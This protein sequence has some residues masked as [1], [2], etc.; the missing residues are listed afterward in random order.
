MDPPS[1]AFTTQQ[2]SA[3]ASLQEIGGHKPT[4][5]PDGAEPACQEER[6]PGI[7]RPTPDSM[8]S[9]LSLMASRPTKAPA[10]NESRAPKNTATAA[11]WISG[12]MSDRQMHA[13]PD[14]E[15]L[16]PCR[17]A[18]TMLL[19]SAACRNTPK[20]LPRRSSSASRRRAAYRWPRGLGQSRRTR[21]QSRQCSAR[22]RSERSLE[23]R[24][25]GRAGGSA[26]ASTT[27][28]PRHQAGSMRRR[29]VADGRGV[30]GGAAS[31]RRSRPSC[32]EVRGEAHCAAASRRRTESA[33]DSAARPAPCGPNRALLCEQKPGSSGRRLTPAGTFSS[34]VRSKPTTSAVTACDRRQYHLKPKTEAATSCSSPC[35]PHHAVSARLVRH[36]SGTSD[37]E[38]Y[39]VIRLPMRVAGHAAVSQGQTVR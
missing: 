25:I 17:R 3:G 19:T 18:T 28:S 32:R 23:R 35:R 14:M 7:P 22:L 2:E 24:P 31:E 20:T 15:T 38:G 8:D 30:V 37:A 39:R 16:Q 6:K 13:R 29:A 36:S 27:A 26:A 34:P 21:G 12:A 11:S 4:H 5:R 10:W 9:A 33:I 1:R